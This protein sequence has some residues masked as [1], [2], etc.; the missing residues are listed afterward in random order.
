MMKSLRF[1]T[2]SIIALFGGILTAFA[3]VNYPTNEIPLS[4]LVFCLSGRDPS[5]SLM[6]MFS[7]AM[8]FLPIYVFCAVTGTSI[9]QH[10]CTASVFVFSRQPKRLRW[11]IREWINLF[12][13]IVLFQSIYI[14]ATII[15]ATI[16]LE[17]VYDLSGVRTLAYH[18]LIHT[19][20]VCFLSVLI[21][22]FSIFLGSDAGF[23][24]GISINT[25]LIT[26]LASPHMEGLQKLVAVNPISRLILAWHNIDASIDGVLDNTKFL[27]DINVSVVY[28][29]VLN[30]AVM[31]A[32]GVVVMRY[33]LLIG[34][35]ETG[36]V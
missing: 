31:I 34:N 19:F 22:I 24:L 29:I 18:F 25:V 5:N 36:G 3:Y 7:L 35:K 33:D 28:M 1:G 11:Y 15:T 21:N 12:L 2:V 17:V 27:L 8:Q 23:V 4:T 10:F 14:G 9:Y 30:I 6:D 26:I 13:T 16:R 20:W 32:C